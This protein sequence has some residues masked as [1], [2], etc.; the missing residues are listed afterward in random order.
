MLLCLVPMRTLTLV[1]LFFWAIQ[2]STCLAQSSS[3][4]AAAKGLSVNLQLPPAKPESHIPEMVKAICELLAALA[5]PTVVVGVLIASRR[6]FPKL[7][8]ALTD[9][10][11]RS[12]H[13]KI[14]E[15]IDV[16]VNRAGKKAEQKTEMS[17]DI[18][19]E[20]RNA[21]D[22]I[23]GFLSEVR[24]SDIQKRLSEFAREYEETRG[25]MQPGPDR[26]R[27][28]NAIVS[29]MHT[30]AILAKPLLSMFAYSEQPGKRLVAISILELSPSLDY[31]PWLV[32]RMSTEM[33]FLLFHSGLALRE[34]ARKYKEFAGP[35][36][37]TA[38]TH[39]LE[40]LDQFER[41]SGQPADVTTRM[42]LQSTLSELGSAPA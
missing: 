25:R 3:A 34:T 26:T 39:S 19:V 1:L 11:E 23:G 24:L 35:G 13:V 28:M 8:T 33:P 9:L 16:E 15:L 38:I 12:D 10:V 18:P 14:L 40:V 42:V 6:S 2:S 22:R 20:D 27:A 31:V 29:R 36:L 17:S 30:L 37:R 21:A 7:V 41:Q 32:E 4:D 5:W